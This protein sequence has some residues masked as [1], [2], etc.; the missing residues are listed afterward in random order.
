LGPNFTDYGQ[1]I[2]TVAICSFRLAGTDGVSAESAK[3]DIALRALGWKTVT[4]AGDGPAD[5]LVPGLAIDAAEPPT[6]AEV[7]D[8]L[9]VADVVVVENLLSLPLNPAA[10]AV[11]ADAL[12]GRPALLRHHDLPWQRARFAAAPPPP[13]DPAWAHVTI[14]RMSASELAARGIKAT[15]IYNA[16][17]LDVEVVPRPVARAE[18]G[19]SPDGLL[20]LQPTRAIARKDVPAGVRLAE[21]LNARFWLTGPAEEDYGPTLAAVLAGA[22]VPVLHRPVEDMALAYAAC[23]VVA[24]PSTFEGFGNPVV[25][26]AICRRPLAVADYPVLRELRSFGFRWFPAAAPELLGSIDAAALAHNRSVAERHFN[27]A[28]LPRRLGDVFDRQGWRP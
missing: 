25:E 2:S 11:V 10:A 14:N 27:A 28:D 21:A 19:L 6:R 23:D 4:V 13:D 8:A 16:F 26:S 12:R 24:F 22:G 20:V 3:W 7:A 18:L 9:A 1:G 5:R 17:N 15:P